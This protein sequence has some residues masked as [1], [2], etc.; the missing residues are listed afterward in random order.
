MTRW[1]ISFLM[2]ERAA[3]LREVHRF[4]LR[5]EAGCPTWLLLFLAAALVAAAFWLYRRQPLKP[6]RRTVLALLRGIA[7]VALLV[8]L[9]RPFLSL[10]GL[11]DVKGQLLIL[12]GG[13]ESMTIQDVNDSGR[14]ISRFDAGRR[15]MKHLMANRE[16]LSRSFL[17][18]YYLYREQV[19]KLDPEKPQELDA[20]APAGTQTSLALAIA[21]ARKDHK[22]EPVS[23]VWFLTDGMH[24]TGE[25]FENTVDDLKGDGVVFLASGLG[26]P[27]ARDIALS[28]IFAED[29]MFVN[30]RAAFLL[31]IQQTGYGGQEIRVRLLVD[32]QETDAKSFTLESVREQTVEFRH[33]KPLQAGKH[34]FRF[35][36]DPK[37]DEMVTKNNALERIVDVIEAQIRVLLYYGSPDWEYRYL[38]GALQRDK[39]VKLTLLMGEM[40]RRFFTVPPPGV[41]KTF[42]DAKKDFVH[43]YD[44]VILGQV[45]AEMLSLPQMEM[46][47][48]FVGEEGGAVVLVADPTAIPGSFKGTPLEPLVP[49]RFTA[50]RGRTLKDELT[51]PLRDEVPLRLTEEGRQH[52]MMRLEDDPPANEKAWAGL[53]P[54]FWYYPPDGLKPSA[55]ALLA[56]RDGRGKGDPLVVYQAYGRGSVLFMGVNDTWRWR[57]QVGE[58]HFRRFWGKVVQYLGLPH[59]TGAS[60]LVT[61][62]TD[63]RTYLTGEKVHVTARVLNADFTPATAGKVTVRLEAGGGAADTAAVDLAALPGRQGL[64]Q[65]TCVARREGEYA[66]TYPGDPQCRPAPFTVRDLQR[67]F[68]YPEMNQKLLQAAAQATGGTLLGFQAAPDVSKVLGEARKTVTAKFDERLWDTWAALLACVLLLALEWFLRKRWYLD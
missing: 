3:E 48:D 58:T 57:Y 47:R 60:S 35:E 16:A 22:G 8:V 6:R 63:K 51:S 31:K 13:T 27:E 23:A 46:L 41:L 30:E 12:L 42:P 1:L 53:L 2:G 44:L 4:T 10:E 29:V 36:I 7:Y 65:G 64:Y 32:G 20:K 26:L 15:T 38:K 50:T 28:H 5:N 18:S 33:E 43:Q 52:P 39:R 21:Q 45:H 24:N 56:A 67:E 17:P 37:P 55:L 54:H 59:L 34:R 11:M 66:L 68:R 14:L 25:F 61:L 19:E 40:D 62:T 49:V 9:V